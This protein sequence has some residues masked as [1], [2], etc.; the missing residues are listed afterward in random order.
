[1]NIL[2]KFQLSSSSGLGLTMFWIYFHKP[3]LNNWINHKAV[4]RTAP[5]TPGLL[6]T[7]HCTV[8]AL[9]CKVHRA[10]V[11]AHSTLRKSHYTLEQSQHT[12]YTTHITHH[13]AQWEQFQGQGF[14]TAIGVARSNKWGANKKSESEEIIFTYCL[15]YCS[16]VYMAL[17]Q[18]V[19]KFVLGY[20]S[21]YPS[22]IYIK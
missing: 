21:I 20:I 10:Y 13:T 18:I 4:C 6:N 22:Y 19:D 7:L 9:Q 1:M 8:S 2:S 5:A 17:N 3:S 11:R 16:T 12:H 14:L 15:N